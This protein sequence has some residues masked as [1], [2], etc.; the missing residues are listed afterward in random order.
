ML[1]SFVLMEIT[2]KKSDYES[3]I[4]ERFP[5]I[6]EH[7]FYIIMF[8]NDERN[9]NAWKKHLATPLLFL[10]GLDVT[11]TKTG[12]PTQ[13]RH[14]QLLFSNYF[15]DNN[16]DPIL[17]KIQNLAS[18]ALQEKRNIH[19]QYRTKSLQV[20]RF[21]PNFPAEKIFKRV[22]HFIQEISKL[23]STSDLARDRIY[24]LVDSV[25]LVHS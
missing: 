11:G 5:R 17:K 16:G 21:D 15:I 10:N 19:S 13:E 7:I 2:I 6:Y 22:Q 23:L 24:N 25:L 12:K 3:K 9:M 4:E 14:Y 20:M 8:S 1:R 18:D